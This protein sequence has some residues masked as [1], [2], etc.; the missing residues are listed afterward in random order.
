M[1]SGFKV[2]K[3]CPYTAHHDPR[4]PQW[5]QDGLVIVLILLFPFFSFPNPFAWSGV[6]IGVQKG[7]ILI[8]GPLFI[9]ILGGRYGAS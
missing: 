2:A 3:S 6:G 9:Q 8:W 7:I 4:E 1:V 5:L